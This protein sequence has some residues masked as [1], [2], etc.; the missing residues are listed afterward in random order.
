V[1]GFSGW[2]AP[3]GDAFRAFELD[4]IELGCVDMNEHTSSPQPRL[5]FIHHA[6]LF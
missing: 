6:F 3:D 1:C 5:A 2:D 4:L